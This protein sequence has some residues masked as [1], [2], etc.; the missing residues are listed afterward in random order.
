[1]VEQVG[2]RNRV[3]DLF[4]SGDTTHVLTVDKP[5]GAL[6]KAA[7]AAEGDWVQEPRIRQAKEDPGPYS[8]FTF[9]LPQGEPGIAYQFHGKEGKLGTHLLVDSGENVASAQ[10]MLE[11]Y[12]GVN[13]NISWRRDS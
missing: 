9:E 4:P 1:M 7:I 12:F 13:G 2:Q 3:V 8:Y 6:R 10:R 5:L 11:S